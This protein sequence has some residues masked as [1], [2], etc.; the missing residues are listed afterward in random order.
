MVLRIFLMLLFDRFH[1]QWDNKAKNMESI[2][3]KVTLYKNDTTIIYLF[4]FVN[5]VLSI[6]NN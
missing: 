5:T 1:V 2:N 6:T 4:T 3:I